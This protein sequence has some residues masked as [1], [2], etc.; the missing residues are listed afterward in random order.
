[1]DSLIEWGYVGLFV[2]TFLAATVLPF[3][4]FLVFFGLIH[5]GWDPW[6]CVAVATVGNTLGGITSYW[7]GR[8]GKTEWMR[9]YMKISKEKVLRFENRMQNRGDWLAVFSV[10]PVVGVVIVVACGY[11]RCN[12]LRTTGVMAFVKFLRYA[13]FCIAW[14]HFQGILFK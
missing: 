11:F 2:A 7:I 3:G 1:M 9:K 6:M 13:C 14:I 4:S 5:K 12:F 10:L 8:L